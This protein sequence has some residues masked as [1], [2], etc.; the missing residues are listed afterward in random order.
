M[1]FS[2]QKRSLVLKSFLLIL[3][4]GKIIMV[5]GRELQH[6]CAMREKMKTVTL[7]KS[8]PSLSQKLLRFTLRFDSF[9]FLFLLL[10]MMILGSI[11]RNS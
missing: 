3:R 7:G 1:V 4:F 2:P 6:H 10:W 5:V 8:R 11:S 9:L